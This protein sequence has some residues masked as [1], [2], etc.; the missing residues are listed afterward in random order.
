MANKTNP[1]VV[2]M[3][4]LLALVGLLVADHFNVIPGRQAVGGED[5]GTGGAG[6]SIETL[7][8]DVTLTYNDVDME[9][10][11]N[12]PASN[13]LIYEPYLGVVADDGTVTL[14]P[15][16]AFMAIAGNGSTTYYGKSISDNAG[17]A[18]QKRFEVELA[19]AGTLTVSAF[20]SDDSQPN[21]ASDAQEIGA[22]DEDVEMEICLDT[23]SNN[24]WGAPQAEG[25]SVVVAQYNKTVIKA[26]E[27]VGQ[28]RADAPSAFS[29]GANATAEEAWNVP[30]VVDGEKV[31]ITLN[32]DATSTE[33]SGAHPLILTFYDANVGLNEKTYEPIFDIEDEDN[34][35]MYLKSTS[36]TIV[37]S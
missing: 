34:T 13:L 3:V 8:E 24:Y 35:A 12:D 5:G 2:I 11:S 22:S 18:D 30:N 16:E 31:C 10:R 28:S 4:I 23:T 36:K 27:V 20:N 26:V 19:K 6:I 17:T 37:L 25:K 21:S 33:T 15:K 32:I 29:R 14:S 7:P 9:D 1:V